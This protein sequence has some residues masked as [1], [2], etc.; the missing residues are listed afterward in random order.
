MNQSARSS[1][2]FTHYCSVSENIDCPLHIIKS[3]NYWMINIDLFIII[4]IQ[5][6]INFMSLDNCFKIC[7]WK[8]DSSI[9]LTR[10]HNDTSIQMSECIT[11][12]TII[13]S[14]KHSIFQCQNRLLLI[15]LI[16]IEP[17]SSAMMI[18]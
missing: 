4:C 7:N 15:L 5:N 2:T 9:Y 8:N 13:Q 18:D 12:S 10:V 17:I 1:C 6:I 3:L 16:S 11:R 14:Q